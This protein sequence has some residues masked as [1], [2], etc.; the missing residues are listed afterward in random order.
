MERKRL[1]MLAHPRSCSTF[2]MRQLGQSPHLR[3]V[4]KNHFELMTPRTRYWTRRY[5]NLPELPEDDA[6]CWDRDPEYVLRYFDKEPNGAFKVI[7][8]GHKYNFV[9]FLKTQ[10]AIFVKLWRRDEASAL[11]SMFSRLLMERHDWQARNEAWMAPAKNDYG[12]VYYADIAEKLNT[13]H[14]HDDKRRR[15]LDNVYYGV[16]V[17]SRRMWDALET[18]YTFYVED[19][20]PDFECPEL[21]EELGITFDFSDFIQPSH[22]SEIFP[23]WKL[24]EQDVRDVLGP[25]PGIS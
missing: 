4:N 13:L 20:G 1:I 9:D 6:E 17:K 25:V 23:D 16:L 7:L 12:K 15:T 14:L 18:P 3:L 19:L 11:A 8:H 2:M 5:L 22:Y 10:D 24:F 21:E